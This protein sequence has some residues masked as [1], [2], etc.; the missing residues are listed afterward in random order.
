MDNMKKRY[1][2][3]PR[4]RKTDKVIFRKGGETSRVNYR[5]LTMLCIIGKWSEQQICKPIDRHLT[6][7]WLYSNG[8]WGYSEGR[9]TEK[10]LH[11]LAEK[12]KQALDEGKIVGVLFIDLRKSF[13]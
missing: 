6:D 8:Q 10:L 2:L 1:F 9:S 11:L 5:P 4:R 3:K 12:W 13:E 7:Y